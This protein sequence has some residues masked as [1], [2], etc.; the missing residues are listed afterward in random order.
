MDRLIS[1]KAVLDAIADHIRSKSNIAKLIVD[2]QAI[3]SEEPKTGHWI[4]VDEKSNTWKCTNC[5]KE[6]KDDWWKLNHGTPQDNKMD[7][8]PHCGAKMV[9]SQESE[10]KE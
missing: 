8:C 5:I 6:G 9:E 10:D 1:E 4:L 7:Y 2:I 3:P